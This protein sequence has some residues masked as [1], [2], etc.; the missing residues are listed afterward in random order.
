MRQG[1]EP[2]QGS[3]KLAFRRRTG[4]RR[5]RRASTEHFAIGKLSCEPVQ[6]SS[7]LTHGKER[8]SFWNTATSQS[9]LRLKISAGQIPY[10]GAQ[11]SRLHRRMPQV[12][13]GCSGVVAESRSARLRRSCYD[14]NA[15]VKIASPKAWFR[16]SEPGDAAPGLRPADGT[17]KHF[18][19]RR[20]RTA[21]SSSPL[22][23]EPWSFCRPE[24]CS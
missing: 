14:R 20:F 16:R 17:P 5:P 23:P 3:K 6:S 19:L 18:M 15:L 7:C 21:S 4:R 2:C 13:C 24:S 11:V 12:N 8:Y 22:P 9:V 1:R 10:S